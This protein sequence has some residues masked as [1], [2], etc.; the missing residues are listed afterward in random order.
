VDS[1]PSAPTVASQQCGTSKDARGWST[2]NRKQTYQLGFGWWSDHPPYHTKIHPT[3]PPHNLD[4]ATPPIIRIWC[5]AATDAGARPYG[6]DEGLIGGGF[7]RWP[8]MP[9]IL[10]IAPSA[11][12]VPALPSP[13]ISN[14][15]AT[16]IVRGGC[17]ASTRARGLAY[18]DGM[19]LNKGPP[20]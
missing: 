7:G 1:G 2:S 3:K 16:H 9:Q 13:A 10:Q 4:K 17:A 5:V 6:N 11:K 20:W 15:A 12:S 14:K 18:D 8:A 19:G